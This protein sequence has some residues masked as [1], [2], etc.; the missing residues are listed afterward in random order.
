MAKDGEAATS[1]IVSRVMADKY[2]FTYKI[3]NLLNIDSTDYL[4]VANRL[5]ELVLDYDARML[6]Y[7]ANGIGAALRD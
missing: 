1:V 7:D 2:F 5:K 6:I 4:V 3:I